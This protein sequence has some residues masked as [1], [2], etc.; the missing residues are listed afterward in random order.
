MIPK[1]LHQLWTSDNDF[2]S[3]FHAFR[4]S[5]MQQNPSWNFRLWRLEDLT[6]P[7]SGFS[8]ICSYMLKKPDLHWVL[9]SDIARWLI[10]WLYGGVYS[11]TD[12]E[13]RKPMDRFLS[14]TAFCANSI[15][16]G[17]AGNAVF[18]GVPGY[19]LYL[20][21]ACAHAEK[22]RD[23]IE[24]ANKTIVDYGVNLAGKMLTKCDKIYP[25]EYFYPFTWGQRREGKTVSANEYPDAYC[26]HH[27]SGMDEGGWYQ[28][29]IGEGK[30]LRRQQQA[31]PPVVFYGKGHPDYNKNADKLKSILASIPREKFKANIVSSISMNQ[32]QIIPK[33]IHRIWIGEKPIPDYSV[34][35]IEK[36]KRICSGYMHVLW[37]DKAIQDIFLFLLP[38][39]VEMLRDER[40]S[41]IIKS[42]ILRYELLRLYGGIYLDMD[43]QLFRSFDD[44]LCIPYFCALDSKKTGSAIQGSIPFH[45]VPRVML[46]KIY[47]NYKNIGPPQ[48]S[49][50]QLTFGG[51]YLLDQVT[52]EFHIKPFNSEMFYFGQEPSCTVHYF[53]GCRTVE[54]WTHKI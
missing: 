20:D 49:Y 34:Y 7:L 10:V 4:V 22:I 53:A 39:S 11:D 37:S 2:A 5:W 33:L 31:Q 17:I 40:L 19:Q 9:K 30:R 44:L 26:I 48:N 50:Q 24:D 51:P 18:G 23:N 28:E 47:F 12:V 25:R 43:V 21:I 54:G 42:D 3:K 52:R 8:A 16:P 15:T 6:Q 32:P 41:P 45:P 36:Q 35:Y 29:T 1:T 38:S 14:D 46:D 13:C 27:W